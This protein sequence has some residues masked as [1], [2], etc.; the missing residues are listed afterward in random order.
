MKRF[1]SSDLCGSFT[2]T[3]NFFSRKYKFSNCFHWNNCKEN[4]AEGGE[5]R[6]YTSLKT[7]HRA[8]NYMGSYITDVI[9]YCEINVT[10]HN[11]CRILFLWLT[12]NISRKKT[13]ATEAQSRCVQ[14]WPDTRALLM[15]LQLQGEKLPG[16]RPASQCIL[17]WRRKGFSLSQSNSCSIDTGLT[18][19][20]RSH[21]LVP[22][23]TSV[24]TERL[25]TAV[26]MRQMFSAADFLPLK[27]LQTTNRSDAEWYRHPLNQRGSECDRI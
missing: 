15:L 16:S 26:R 7:Q 4:L 17:L 5:G 18:E 12:C 13:C 22:A 23:L 9:W 25:N 19:Q 24:G 14:V 1:V 20:I 8:T 10:N 2:S 21:Q 27:F 6:H 11:R 3:A